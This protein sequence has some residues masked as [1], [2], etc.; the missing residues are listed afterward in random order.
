MFFTNAEGEEA[1]GSIEKWKL[2]IEEVQEA[3][4]RG[5]RSCTLFFLS[6]RCEISG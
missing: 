6:S 4:R 5:F 3:Q 2:H 1:A